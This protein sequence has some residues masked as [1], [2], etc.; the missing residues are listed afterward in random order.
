MKI[1]FARFFAKRQK[2]QSLAEM[3]VVSILAIML[4]VGTLSLI[5]LHRARTAATAAAYACAQFLSQSPD[6]AAAAGQADTVANATITSPWS[7]LV[8]ANFRIS[9]A[10][11]GGPGVPGSCTV[12]WTAP[13][14]F[15]NAFGIS[16]GQGSE[17]FYSRSETWKA[18]WKP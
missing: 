10:A 15:G 16:M 17:T 18:D 11:P 12:S 9:V 1:T 7:G 13:F 14:L 3:A 4:A 2:G 8:M 5:T 6:S